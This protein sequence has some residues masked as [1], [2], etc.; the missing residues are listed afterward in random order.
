M[1][2]VMMSGLEVIREYHKT[3]GYC[4]RLYEKPLGL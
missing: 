1:K 4:F 3:I 2:F